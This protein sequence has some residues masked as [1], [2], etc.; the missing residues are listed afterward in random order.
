MYYFLEKNL[1]GF[2]SEVKNLVS[3]YPNEIKINKQSLSDYLSLMY[4]PS[5]NTIFENI[6]RLSAGEILEIDLNNSSYKKKKWFEPN[7]R[8]DNKISAEDV[9][10]N[11]KNIS[12][13]AINEW[14]L[15]AISN[16]LS[17]GIDSSTISYLAKN[18]K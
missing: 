18:Q 5:P 4:I 3:F 9:I 14:S 12:K 10:E 17:G 13:K 2:S 15:K 11:I 16:S 7:F 6:N 8:P 1:F